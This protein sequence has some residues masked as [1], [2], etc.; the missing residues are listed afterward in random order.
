MSLRVRTSHDP[1]DRDPVG[2]VGRARLWVPGGP[3]PDVTVTEVEL[4]ARHPDVRVPT[5]DIDAPQMIKALSGVP[6]ENAAMFIQ[7]A[8]VSSEAV[9]GSGQDDSGVTH[10]RLLSRLA[11]AEPDCCYVVSWVRSCQRRADRTNRRQPGWNCVVPRHFEK[12]LREWRQKD[13]ALEED[14]RPCPT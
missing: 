14:F 13:P 1:A 2:V 7:E 4:A 9:V 10:G 5:V 12:V 6:E 11:E 8:Q 3:R